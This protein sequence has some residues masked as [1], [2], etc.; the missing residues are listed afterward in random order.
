[1][2]SVRTFLVFEA[3]RCE[4]AVDAHGQG[5]QS[6]GAPTDAGP[7]NAGTSRRWKGSKSHQPNV[8]RR[9]A[10]TGLLQSVA[11]VIQNLLPDIAQE[12]QGQVD[13]L[14]FDPPHS[15]AVVP[16]RFECPGERRCPD[17]RRWEDGDEGSHRFASDQRREPGRGGCVLSFRG[18]G[19]RGW[20]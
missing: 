3:Q 10:R 4:G 14:G 8:E 9:I 20:L 2:W 15:L 19:R 17:L 18:S 7:Q 16:H 5:T 11:E 13:V 6:F 1:M 12:L